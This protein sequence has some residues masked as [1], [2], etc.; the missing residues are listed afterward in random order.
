MAKHEHTQALG[1]FTSSSC[2]TPNV[3]VFVI[4]T[5]FFLFWVLYQLS[6]S[7]LP[8]PPTHA[9]TRQPPIPHNIERTI[10]SGWFT[11][12]LGV[13]LLDGC[14]LGRI[15]VW[16]IVQLSHTAGEASGLLELVFIKLVTGFMSLFLAAG[17]VL[18]AWT[19]IATAR[20]MARSWISTGD[21]E[22]SGGVI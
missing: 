9:T 12:V 1:I 19:V 2:P 4:F 5:I 15:Y 10:I 18:W 21:P 11:I 20:Q 17:F 3:F 6:T 14:W 8:R 7:S 13:L 16:T 22:K